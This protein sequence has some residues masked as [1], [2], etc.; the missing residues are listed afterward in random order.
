MYYFIF[1]AKI[2]M[3][4][5]WD[6]IVFIRLSICASFLSSLSINTEKGIEGG[7]VA[8]FMILTGLCSVD[9]LSP[10]ES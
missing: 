7:G 8:W 10:S 1:V 2:S 3:V 9:F 5:C 4:C 6:A